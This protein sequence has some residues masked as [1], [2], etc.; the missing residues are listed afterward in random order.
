MA[1]IERSRPVAIGY[2][3]LNFSFTFFFICHVSICL[4][5]KVIAHYT[6]V[7]YVLMFYTISLPGDLVLF[8]M[9]A[10]GH[11]PAPRRQSLLRKYPI[12]FLPPRLFIFPIS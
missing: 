4:S 9:F 5:C 12:N 3:F 7:M 11:F 6:R 2:I 1:Y 8:I 10:K